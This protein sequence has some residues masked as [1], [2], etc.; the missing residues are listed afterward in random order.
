MKSTVETPEL[1]QAVVTIEVEYEELKP[2]FTN[3]Y[4][5]IA[6]QVNVPG[7]R[8]G[9]VPP[10]I[11]DQRFGRGLVIQDVVNRVVPTYL[12]EA[13]DEHELVSLG[14]PNVDVRELPNEKGAPGGK[15]VFA[16]NLNVVA[17]FELPEYQ[18]Y[19][20]EVDP[21]EA[22]EAAVERELTA[23]RKRFAI[24]KTVERPA[25]DEDFLTI[26]IVAKSGDEELDSMIG[27]SYELGSGTMLEGQDE[28]LR[29]ASA[30]D[31]V[32]FKAT[33]PGGEHAGKEADI[34]VTL[35]SVKER[36][37]PEV[38]D[39]F[40]MMV[41]EFDTAEE[42]LEDLRKV[43]GKVK[44]DEQA[45]QARDRLL[46]KL[47][48][49]AQIVLPEPVVEQLIG[50][51]T[52]E[53]ATDE[54]KQKAREAIERDIRRTVL[55]D[56]LGK[57][58]DVQV[59]QEELLEFL[60]MSARQNNVDLAQVVSNPDQMRNMTVELGRNKSL[61]L[62][63]REVAVKDTDGNPV[64]LSDY[65]KEVV[66]NQEAALEVLAEEEAERAAAEEADAEDE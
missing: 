56:K 39:D 27:V 33:L 31:Q 65:T 15:L 20:L 52:G 46:D 17:P 6:N 28:V 64:D 32:E 40:A 49:D 63:L 12:G 29:G 37:L 3:A 47:L 66:E 8:K 5:E 53:D 13:I 19:E 38:D 25:Q 59:T 30:G 14:Q 43:V 41:S 45:I 57:S 22:D 11:I 16:A 35:V 51:A 7:F 55:L 2:E 48:D 9:H 26:D 34:S 18:G 58:V 54:D 60:V 36:E 44:R 21:V 24:L 23:L 61:V 4:K 10:R 1:T 62:A 42:M 50:E